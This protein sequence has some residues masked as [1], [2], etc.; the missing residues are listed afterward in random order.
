MSGGR[1]EKDCLVLCLTANN[2]YLCKPEFLA[3]HLQYGRRNAIIDKIR[4][5]KQSW[6][7]FTTF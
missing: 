3:E 7:T 6:V 1:V 5:Q 2:Q 4:L